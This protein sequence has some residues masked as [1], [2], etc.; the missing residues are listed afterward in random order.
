MENA[1]RLPALGERAHGPRARDPTRRAA[2]L[3]AGEAL[4]EPR[5]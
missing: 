4:S 3:D 5:G 1:K 2:T